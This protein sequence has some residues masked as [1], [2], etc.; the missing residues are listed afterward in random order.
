MGIQQNFKQKRKAPPGHPVLFFPSRSCVVEALKLPGEEKK[1][2][3]RI[4]AISGKS[5]IEK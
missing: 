3:L 4:S 1:N 5:T 2:L